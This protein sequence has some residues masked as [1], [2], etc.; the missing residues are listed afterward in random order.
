MRLSVLPFALFPAA[1]I[2]CDLPPDQSALLPRQAGVASVAAV[3]DHGRAS[4]RYIVDFTD[5]S[6]AVV[7]DGGCPRRA[8]VTLFTPGPLQGATPA[9]IAA[10]AGLIAQTSAAGMPGAA[11]REDAVRAVL[12]ADEAVQ[13]V[14][15]RRPAAWDVTA[16][17]LP[18]GGGLARASWAPLAFPW[19]AMLGIEIQAD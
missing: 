5:R 18:Q 6:M 16:V 10:V 2:A 15:D 1:A 7:E 11:V 3:H 17:L 19:G 8:S 12:A 4:W 14:Q 13:A 9:Q